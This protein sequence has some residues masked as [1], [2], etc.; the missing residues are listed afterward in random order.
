VFSYKYVLTATI[1]GVD[2]KLTSVSVK[3]GNPVSYDFTNYT[4]NEIVRD[5]TK[6][7]FSIS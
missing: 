5:M 7:T 2:T 6:L 4:F 3:N 1:N